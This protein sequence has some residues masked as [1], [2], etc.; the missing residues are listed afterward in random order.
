V[1]DNSARASPD[2]EGRSEGQAGRARAAV[3][4]RAPLAQRGGAQQG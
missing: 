3:R 1:G 4:T 2:R